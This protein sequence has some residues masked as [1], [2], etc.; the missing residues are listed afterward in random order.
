M[1]TRNRNNS[2]QPYMPRTAGQFGGNNQSSSAY[3][4]RAYG[5]FR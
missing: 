5:G 2:P 1:S 4:N 3:G